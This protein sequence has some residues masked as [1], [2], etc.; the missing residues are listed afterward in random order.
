MILELLEYLLTPASRLARSMGFL[1]SALQVRSRFLRCANSWAP[2]LQ[3]TRQLLLEAAATCPRHRKAVLLGAGL[4]HDIPLEE[5]ARQFKSVVL[6]DL[7]HPLPS[8]WATRRFP[9]VT[10]CTADISGVMAELPA[11]LRFPQ[12]PLPRSAPSLFLSDPELDMTVSVNLLSQLPWVPSQLLEKS[13]PAP[14]LEPFLQ[15]LLRAHLDYLTRLPGHCALVTDVAWRREHIRTGHSESWDV[16]HGVSLPP[17]TR[18]W[19]WAIAPAPE[20]E[21]DHHFFAQVAGYP[22][23]KRA[24]REQPHGAPPFCPPED[25]ALGD[26]PRHPSRDSE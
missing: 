9:N 16:L 24:A 22:D 26:P 12:R 13:H 7:V 3:H 18:T 11:A 17:P 1:R 15:H 8:R 10:R 20:R 14:V 5:L 2:H 19:E 23:W 21:S 4:L 6:V 25:P